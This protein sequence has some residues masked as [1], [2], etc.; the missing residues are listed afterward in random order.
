MRQNSKFFAC[1][2]LIDDSSLRSSIDLGYINFIPQTGTFFD[3]I[4]PIIS[5]FLPAAL[6]IF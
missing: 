4:P 1:G 5:K 6:K 3:N 2:G